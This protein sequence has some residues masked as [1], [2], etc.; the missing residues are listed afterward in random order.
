[1]ENDTLLHADKILIFNAAYAAS[2][3]KKL[4]LLW[5]TNL[6]GKQKSTLSLSS[7]VRGSLHDIPSTVN[8]SCSQKINS[9]LTT[10]VFYELQEQLFHT[11]LQVIPPNLSA[12]CY[13]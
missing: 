7:T 13:D 4:C 2:K 9:R 10:N 8:I 1:M 12:Q 6:V 11:S 3:W 5:W